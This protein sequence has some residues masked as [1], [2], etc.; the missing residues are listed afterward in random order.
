MYEYILVVRKSC[1]KGGRGRGEWEGE[2]G[3]EIIRASDPEV[4]YGCMIGRASR[5]EKVG[6]GRE[7][8]SRP[9]H[10]TSL[11]GEEG[12]SV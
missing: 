9:A 12:L 1:V 3:E 4:E 6:G 11:Q 8:A 5:W 2:G 7:K 10:F